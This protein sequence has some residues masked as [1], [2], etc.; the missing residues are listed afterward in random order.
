MSHHLLKRF[1]PGERF[2]HWVH[3]ITFM[4]LALT[5]LGLYAKSFFGLTGLFG[6]VDISRVIHHWAG[7]LFTG[8]T[9]VIFIQWMKDI[10]APGEDTVVGVVKGYF[11]PGFKVPPSGK[12]NAGQKMAGW[13]ALILG[14]IMAG[15]GLAMWFPFQL[16][17]GI[18]QWMYLFHNLG[19]I[20]FVGFIMLHAYLGTVGV[21]GTW[22]AMSRGTVT[23]A[24][25][26]KN[27]AKWDAEEA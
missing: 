15:T 13:A 20:I 22:R 17:R 21:P 9:L 18:Q 10:T 11:D 23:R 27:H 16:S 7:I 25:A 26:S 8:T 19:F 2:F 24:W 12:F 6:G 1:N 3:M 5:G 4:I 14:L